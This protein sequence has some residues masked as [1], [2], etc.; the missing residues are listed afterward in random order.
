[1]SYEMLVI[2]IPSSSYIVTWLDQ[3]SRKA[4]ANGRRT[5][6]LQPCQLRWEVEKDGAGY[7]NKHAR[8]S[9]MDR[10]FGKGRIKVPPSSWSGI[11]PAQSNTSP[12][13]YMPP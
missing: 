11:I 2:S 4:G 8:Y 13:K 10:R 9:D 6:P 5:L 3:G 7:W 12:C 1:M